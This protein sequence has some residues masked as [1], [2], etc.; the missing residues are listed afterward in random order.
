MNDTIIRFLNSLDFKNDGIHIY[1]KIYDYIRIN[2]YI[3]SSNKI[4]LCIYDRKFEIYSRLIKITE[5]RMS[6]ILTYLGQLD[7]IFT[8]FF[9]KIGE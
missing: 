2:I 6:K 8:F 9:T 4:R 7:N 5:K 1:E 3:T